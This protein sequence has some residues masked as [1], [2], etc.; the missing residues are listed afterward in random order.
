MADQNQIARLPTTVLRDS[1]GWPKLG[2]ETGVL[3]M[4]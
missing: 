2:A 3:V 4:V 1:L